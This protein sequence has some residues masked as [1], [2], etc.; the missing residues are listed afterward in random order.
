MTVNV[1]HFEDCEQ[2]FMS[3][4]NCYLIEALLAFFNMDNINESPKIQN[5]CSSNEVLY[6]E[7]K[8]HA[9]SVLGHF[10]DEYILQTQSDDKDIA[11]DDISDGVFDYSLNLL[12]SFMVF[13]DCKDA[14]AS[15]NGEHL[16]IIQKQ[17]IWQ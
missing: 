17:M 15:G 5:P 4:G 7:K 1:K 3:V 14:V 11:A 10:L 2:L 13:L 6:D 8:A 9:L 16:A 12:K